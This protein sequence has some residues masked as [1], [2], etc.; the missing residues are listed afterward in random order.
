V[1]RPWLLGAAALALGAGAWWWTAQEAPPPPA[2]TAAV[3]APRGV[4]ALGRVEPASRIRRLNQPGGM[5][6]T[7]LE[8]LLVSEGDEVRQGQL[9]AEFADAAQKDAAAAQAEAAL[10]EARASLERTRAAGRPS[11]VQ[12]QRARIAALA[13]QEE[14]ARRDAQRTDAL[15]PTGAGSFA[16]AERNRYLA[17]QLANQRAQAEADLATLSTPRPEDVALAEARVTQM[18]A[19]LDKARADAALARVRAPMD[20][21]ILRIFARPGDQV[22][23]DG[24]LEM[25]DLSRLDVV[26][27]V[28]ET[29]LPRVRP[30]APAQVIIPGEAMRMP[31]TVRELGWTVRRTTQAGSDPVAAVDAR[32]VEV[33]LTLSDEGAAL[34]RRRSGMQVQ[35]H[36]P[37]EGAPRVA[38]AR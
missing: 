37:A 29:D 20:G 38:A 10:A 18:Q 28:F 19:A 15:V 26:A 24:L 12:A 32:T 3:E 23:S 36:I 21:T 5:A 27:D 7:R 11:E 17:L 30:G 2:P 33:R 1:K 34:L 9:L 14:I 25:A 13:A 35:V 4:G 31:A 8:R 22:G 6:V 16:V